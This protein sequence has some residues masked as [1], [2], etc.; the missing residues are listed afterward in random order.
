MTDASEKSDSE[1][2]QSQVDVGLGADEEQASDEESRNVLQVI[3]VGS[4]H[5][6]DIFI[7]LN[8]HVRS[9]AHIFGILICLV[10][11]NI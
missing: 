4:S 11:R 2:P 9:I 8:L 7:F 1:E 3:Q 10:K 5:S 6:L